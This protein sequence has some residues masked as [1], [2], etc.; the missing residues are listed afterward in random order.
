MAQLDLAKIAKKTQNLSGAD[1]K[2][3]C[4]TAVELAM[5]RSVKSGRV[6]PIDQKL[7]EKA[8]KSVKPSVGPWLDTARNYVTFANS[9]GDYDELELYLS[10]QRR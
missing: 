4:D 10:S 7:L 9:D 5:E 6:E 2:L 3:I 1:L 8:A